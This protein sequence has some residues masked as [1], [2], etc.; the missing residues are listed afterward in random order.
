MD[1]AWTTW[2]DW[3]TCSLT[4]GIGSYSRTRSCS[5]PYPTSGG[6]DCVG[7]AR[8]TSSCSISTGCPVDGGW[9]DWTGWLEC[10]A[11]CGGGTRGR[12]RTCTNPLPQNGGSECSGDAIVEESC[13][14][15]LPCPIDGGW[16]S[17][18]SWGECSMSCG[19]GVQIRQR[20]CNNPAP[21]HGGA[22]CPDSSTDSQ[23]CLVGSCPGM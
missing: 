12:T 16:S 14:T 20:V 13:N 23:S 11:S 10:S 15:L 4:C 5:N 22:D 7:E 3:S 6:Q 19:T 17:W 9:S 21:E 1:G 8:E 18:Q 2:T